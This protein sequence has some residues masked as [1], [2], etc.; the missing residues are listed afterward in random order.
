M[1]FEARRSGERRPSRE[2]GGALTSPKVRVLVVDDSVVMR[3][4]LTD[5]LSSDPAIE[6]V[7]AAPSGK[8]ALERIPQLNPDVVTLDVEMPDMDGLEMLKHLRAKYPRLPV[9][10]FSTLTQRG[11][12]TTLDALALGAND[13]V[14]KPSGSGGS[15]STVERIREDLLR[16][17]KGLGGVSERP[18]KR[19]RPTPTVAPRA[20]ASPAG[21]GTVDVVAIAT[22]TGGPNA[23]DAVPPVLPKDFQV[24]VVVVQHMPLH[25]T[26]LLAERLGTRC[27][28]GVYEAA[29][30]M[31]IEP[32]NVYIAPGDFHLELAHRGG[33]F[34]AVTHQGAPENSCRPAADVLFRS[35]AKVFRGGSLGVVLTGMGKDGLRGAEAIRQQGGH[36]LAQDQ[37]TS[38]VW[39]MPGFVVEAGLAEEV[40]PIEKVADALMRRVQVSAAA[41]ARSLWGQDS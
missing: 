17:V 3:R 30:G 29:D 39:G 20:A 31:A 9:V 1:S 32:G 21:A 7:G 13:Y 28:L 40:L 14:P 15:N 18:L 4:L 37:A 27:A 38:V 2:K 5:T 19:T 22:S 25:F 26:K 8:L 36:V 11:A 12:V 10:I 6:V 34:V 24:P 16:K 41:R 33:R 35:V 23:L